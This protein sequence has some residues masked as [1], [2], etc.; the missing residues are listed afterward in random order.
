VVSGEAGEYHLTA[1]G[2]AEPDDT[3][4]VVMNAHEE[5]VDYKLPAFQ[6]A[7]GW[8]LAIDTA[9]QEGSGEPRALAPAE[10]LPI[11]P[12]SLAVFVMIDA[13]AARTPG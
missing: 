8:Q 11:A 6:S 10:T 5:P 7:T 2:E 9:A 1:A 3:F 4:L 12:R 13:E